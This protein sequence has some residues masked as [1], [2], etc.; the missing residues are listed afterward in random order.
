MMTVPSG[1]FGD[2]LVT[3]RAESPLFFPEVQE[4]SFSLER[5][6]HLHIKPFLEVGFPSRIIGI[7]LGANLRVPLNGYRVGGEQTHHLG[8]PLLTFE[9][10]SEHPPIRA[11]GRPVFL[12]D[13]PARFVAVSPLCPGPEGF[14]D[15][16]IDSMKH[17]L[18]HRMTMIPGPS[19]DLWTRV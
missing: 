15:F 10:P 8:L 14:E 1:D 2:L 5:A 17:I 13:P 7:G 18:A 19:T 16:M 3:D 4:P 9:D 6:D 11:S 12:L